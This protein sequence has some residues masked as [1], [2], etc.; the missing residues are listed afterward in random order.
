VGY[1]G[2][3]EWMNAGNAMLGFTQQREKWQNNGFMKLDQRT[4][5]MKAWWQDD[6]FKLAYPGAIPATEV[7]KH[8]LGWVTQECE[9][10]VKLY[11]HDDERVKEAIEAGCV[12]EVKDSDGT[13]VSHRFYNWILDPDTKAIVRPDIENVFG[14][15]GVDSY[16]KH[17]YMPL[18][19]QCDKIADGEL[20]IASAFLMDH[21]AV[22]IIGMELPEDITTEEGI[23]HRVRLQASTSQ[24]GRFATRFD[25][26]D[27]FA[28]CSNSFKLNLGKADSRADKSG[29]GTFAVKHTSKSLGR[30]LDARTALGLVYKA[31]DEFTKFLDAMTQVDVTNDQFQAIV[32][33]LVVMPE[34]KIVDGKQTNKGAQTIADGKRDKLRH[35]WNFDHRCR[36]FNGTLFGAFQTWSTWNQWERPTGDPLEASIMGTLTGKFNDTDAE[37]FS[38]VRGMEDLNLGALVAAAS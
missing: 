23:D 38:I 28:V 35:M 36:Q 32:N 37:F 3:P 7:H 19:E 1:R 4:G 8:L 33:N 21:G 26:V 14:Y 25:L 9:V 34:A 10:M 15:F 11:V 27:E 2:E 18:I 17:D 5:A 6:N 12:E 29:K 24:N 20:G 13:V 22:F 31:T 30:I 16:E